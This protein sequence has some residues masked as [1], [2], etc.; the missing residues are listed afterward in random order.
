M[1]TKKKPVSSKTYTN[2]IIRFKEIK[3]MITDDSNYNILD[4][5]SILQELKNIKNSIGIYLN[6]QL[7]VINI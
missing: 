3:E 5:L 6:K 7:E 1:K 4:L 2:T